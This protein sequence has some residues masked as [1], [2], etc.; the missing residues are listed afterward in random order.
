M[1]YVKGK[2]R[3]IMLKWLMII[4]I[5]VSFYLKLFI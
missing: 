3:H 5:H 4:A 1:I 2:L